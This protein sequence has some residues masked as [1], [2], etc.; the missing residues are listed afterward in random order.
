MLPQVRTPGPA[1]LC[2]DEEVKILQFLMELLGT[3]G[4]RVLIAQSGER[5]RRMLQFVSVEAVVLDH[6]PPAIDGVAL[7]LDLKRM[8][9]AI[10]ILGYSAAPEE[11]PATL[12]GLAFRILQK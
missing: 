5:A 2:I 4:Y 9:P 11:V 8:D 10:P 1:V 6:Q 3:G 12:H 7:S